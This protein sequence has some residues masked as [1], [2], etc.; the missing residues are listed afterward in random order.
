MLSLSPWFRVGAADRVMTT[1]VEVVTF[2]KSI[3][4]GSRSSPSMFVC[5]ERKT[6]EFIL[7]GLASVSAFSC[8]GSGGIIPTWRLVILQS[9]Q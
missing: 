9:R 5:H 6:T 8:F 4:H 1:L 2:L 3:P 7:P